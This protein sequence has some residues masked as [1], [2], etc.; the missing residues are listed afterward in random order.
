MN[1]CGAL[2]A[3][4]EYFRENKNP[5]K[6][7]FVMRHFSKLSLSNIMKHGVSDVERPISVGLYLSAF[8]NY[9]CKRERGF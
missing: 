5:P 2:Y 6:N 3:L 7:P 4:L 9:L 8:W 1:I